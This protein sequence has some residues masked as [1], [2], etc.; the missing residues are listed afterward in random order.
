[1]ILLLYLLLIQIRILP[2]KENI[3]LEALFSMC[4]Y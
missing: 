2:E 4:F 3:F 1:M